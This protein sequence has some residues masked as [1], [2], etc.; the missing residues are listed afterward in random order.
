MTSLDW[1]SDNVY[2]KCTNFCVYIFSR[3][4]VDFAK[5]SVQRHSRKQI[6]AKVAQDLYFTKHT[7]KICTKLI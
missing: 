3:I 6:H 1:N 7:K 4:L 5:F 2:L